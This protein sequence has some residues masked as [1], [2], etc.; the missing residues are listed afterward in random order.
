MVF[1]NNKMTLFSGGVATTK[2]AMFLRAVKPPL[3]KND[4]RKGCKASLSKAVLLESSIPIK[5]DTYF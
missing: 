3:R 4:P 5:N 2:I 1:G